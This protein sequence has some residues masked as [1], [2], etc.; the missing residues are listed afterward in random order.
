MQLSVNG[1]EAFVATGGKE[2]DLSQPTIVLLHAPASTTPPGPCTAV[3]CPSWLWRAGSDLP[4]TTF[5]RAR[6]SL[7]SPTWPIGPRRLLRRAG[8]A[9]ARLVGHPL[10]R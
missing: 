9:T 2:F 3:V 8:A 6:R 5:G 7:P 1:L 10:D 4:G